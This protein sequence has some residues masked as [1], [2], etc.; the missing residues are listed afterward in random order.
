MLALQAIQQRKALLRGLQLLRVGG[1]GLR[2]AAQ[3]AGEVFRLERER[4]EPR[5]ERRELRIDRG[6]GL[7]GRGRGGQRRRL[8]R[9]QGRPH[10]VRQG[11]GVAQTLAVGRPAAPPP[12]PRARPARSPP[13]PSPGGPAHAPA[14][15][16]AP[17][18]RPARRPASAPPRTPPQSRHGARPAR[19]RRS[20]RGS[21]AA[22]R[23]GSAAG[24]RAARRRTTAR[25][26]ARR[27]RPPSP[28]A[29]R[30]RRA[31]APRPTPAGPARRPR[32]PARRRRPPRRPRRRPGAR[33]SPAAC[34]PAADPAR[35][36]GR[37]CPPRSPP[38]A[39]SAPAPAGAPPA[40]SG[41]GSRRAAHPAR[42][43]V[44]H[45]VPTA[46][47]VLFPPLAGANRGPCTRRIRALAATAAVS[48]Y[49]T[50]T[51]ARAERAVA[52]PRALA[53]ERSRSGVE[54]RARELR[55]VR[56]GLAELDGQVLA[57]RAARRSAGRRRGPRPRRRARGC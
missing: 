8:E 43:G 41:A 50:A 17:A 1:H 21:P 9:A 2:V 45:S 57:A 15:R 32:R 27:D 3:I 13:A 46:D 19:A 51:P 29:R 24:A 16:H 28:H 31:S 40:R 33:C 39:R 56:V 18:A 4:R 23:R 22:P 47:R 20:C 48:A 36:R 7:R 6:D 55:E 34:R 54:A 10:R 5:A 12:A 38:S 44:N 35:A 49:D 14:R 37:S 52:N 11:V 26:R 30:R 25:R 53:A 42:S